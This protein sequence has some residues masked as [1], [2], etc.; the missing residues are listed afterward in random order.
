MRSIH[1]DALGVRVHDDADQVHAVDRVVI[2]T[3]ADTALSLLADP[4][5]QE[6]RALSAFGYSS[7]DTIL[8]TDPHLLPTASRARA[9]WNYLLPGC[10]ASVDRVL[11]SYDMNRLQSLP[12]ATPP[13][14]TL[15]APDRVAADRVIARMRYEH[16]IYTTGAV[17]AQQLLPGLND[18]RTA[19]A[20]A[21]HG[22]GFHEDG[23][24]AG[25]AAAASLGVDW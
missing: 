19:F 6:R 5:E 23:C 3:H 4:T 15:N 20:G 16:P 24:R 1:R 18:G 13:V 9:S 12:T 21:Y 10:D 11:V 17:A 7:N 22:W 2:A 8:H 14:V 25:V